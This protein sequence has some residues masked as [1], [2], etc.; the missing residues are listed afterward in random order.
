[1]IHNSHDSK[2]HCVRFRCARI[3]YNW[4]S[5]SGEDDEN[6]KSLRTDERQ[7]KFDQKSSV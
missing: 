5:G 6:I 3:G 7:T 2:S 1:M 4:P